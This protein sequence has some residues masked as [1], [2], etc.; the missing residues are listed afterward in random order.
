MCIISGEAVVSNTQIFTFA[1]SNSRQVMV[2]S[3]RINIFG[4]PVSMILPFPQGNCQMIDI[5]TADGLF[6]Q[7]DEYFPKVPNT[8]SYSLSR[9][10]ENK[11]AVTR[12]GSYQYSIVNTIDDFDNIQNNIFSLTS[13]VKTVLKQ[14]YSTGFSF[15]VCIIDKN[16]AYAPIAYVHQMHRGNLFIPTRH[17]H[18]DG[19]TDWDH[20]IYVIGS[21]SFGKSATPKIDKSDIDVRP[22]MPDALAV[23]APATVNAKMFRKKKILDKKSMFNEVHFPNDDIIVPVHVSTPSF[24]SFISFLLSI[25][26]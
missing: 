17:E 13:S 5:G 23:F 20:S 4:N 9:S 7:L 19:K 12:C 21:D 26:S 18:S 10:A 11:I 25:W 1:T 8:F 15:L 24:F 14:H 3:N 6:S 22:D 16:A 2:Y